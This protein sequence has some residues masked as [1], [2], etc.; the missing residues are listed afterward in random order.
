MT[1]LATATPRSMKRT[2]LACAAGALL[3]ASAFTLAPQ[4]Q[5][6]T[7]ISVRIAPPLLPVYEQPEMPGPGYMWTPGYWAWDEDINDYYW[8]PGTW[9]LAPYSGALWTPGYWGWNDGAYIFHSGYWGPHVGYY[10]GINYGYG[11]IGVGYVGGYWRHDGFYYNSAYNHVRGGGRIHVYERREAGDDAVNHFSFNGPGG[12]DHHASAEE[13]RYE[14]ERHTGPSAV[15]REHMD[16]ARHDESLRSGVNHGH[17]AVT[18]SAHP[19]DFDH[20]HHDNDH[21]K[22]KDSHEHEGD[23]ASHGHDGHDDSSPHSSSD[24]GSPAMGS[25]TSDHHHHSGH[26]HASDHGQPMMQAHGG[27]M[28]QRGS[29]HGGPGQPM[30][31]PHQ[32]A[33][34]KHAESH[35]S[36]DHKHDHKH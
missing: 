14:H 7:I 19:G 24:A 22:D 15:Q 10:G 1:P 4:A 3:A 9:V 21:A 31:A 18:A 26:S 25:T 33:P 13:L 2:L 17:P 36:D 27:M 8:V 6:S 34:P 35:P 16:K 32:P 11:Y 30:G 29:Q 12:V 23:K 28:P 5:A 20:G